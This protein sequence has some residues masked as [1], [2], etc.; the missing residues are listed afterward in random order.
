MATP[1]SS[2]PAPVR[3]KKSPPPL[4][5]AYQKAHRTYVL[6]AALLASWELIGIELN[7]KEKWGVELKSPK[8]VPLILLAMIVYF[9]YRVTVEWM[10]CDEERR[11]H[12]AANVDF[13]VA[14]TIAAF[15][16]LI[17]FIQYLLHIRIADTISR[18]P[19][20]VTWVA[21]ASFAF[22]FIVFSILR[23]L[24]TSSLRVSHFAVLFFILVAGVVWSGFLAVAWRAGPVPVLGGATVGFFGGFASIVLFRVIPRMMQKRRLARIAAKQ[25]AQPYN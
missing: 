3:K 14:H 25:Q 6:S 24:R 4:S 17:S 2:Q 18:L 10:Q 21:I 9:G 16:L 12:R 20:D 1:A 8:A 15:A 7:T 13:I 19:S 11:S 23:S 5:N 22:S